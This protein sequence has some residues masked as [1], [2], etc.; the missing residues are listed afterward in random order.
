MDILTLTG[1]GKTA[2]RATL[3]KGHGILSISDTY[4]I[5]NGKLEIDNNILK[6]LGEDTDSITLTEG[7]HHLVIKG[8]NIE[9]ITRDI[10]IGAGMAPLYI[11]LKDDVK[12]KTGWLSVQVNTQGYRLFV[13]NEE[14]PADQPVSLPYGS[15]DVRVEK[16]GYIP[17]EKTVVVNALSASV[18]M[19]LHPLA[20]LGKII[21]DSVPEGAQVYVDSAYVGDTPIQV[22]IEMGP[23]TLLVSK[24]GYVSISFPITIERDSEPYNTYNI[25]LNPVQP[26]L[27]I[28]PF[29]QWPGLDQ[30]ETEQP[31]TEQPGDGQPEA[32]A[33]AEEE[34]AYTP[35]LPT[36]APPGSPRGAY[37]FPSSS[38]AGGGSGDRRHQSIFDILSP[39]S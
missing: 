7:P 15:H 39:R 36:P 2:W 17:S 5:V 14:K 6:N 38:Q 12:L 10:N 28:P 33:P 31:Q 23:H 20:R 22:S 26:T 3:V 24:D 29:F 18:N 13:D 34:P 11:S 16:D 9:T 1:V 30:P 4:N 25:E 21:A 32:G 27:E 35:E 37:T 19:D 8:D